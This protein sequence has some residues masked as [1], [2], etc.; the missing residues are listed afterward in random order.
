MI[1]MIKYAMY[2]RLFIEA[3]ESMLL[4]ATSEIYEKDVEEIEFLFSYF[5]ACGVF[6]ISIA[7]PIISFYCYL[8]YRKTFDPDHKFFF[9]EFFADIRN[10]SIARL[11][12]TLL[13]TRR[14][15]FVSVIIFL[16]VAPREFQYPLIIS[17][18]PFIIL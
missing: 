17:K 6:L 10:A 4:S 13:L 7:L 8:K 1:G 9:M 15:V 2:L 5:A 16:D 14:I 18:F 11:Y 12:M 3:H